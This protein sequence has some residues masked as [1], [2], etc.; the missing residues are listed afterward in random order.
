MIASLP[1]QLVINCSAPHKIANRAINMT[2]AIFLVLTIALVII[3]STTNLF[4]QGFRY[5]S[6]LI[7]G[8]NNQ[9]VTYYQWTD[10]KG[11]MVVSRI[12]PGSE[13]EYMAFQASEDLMTSENKVDQELINKGN[14]YRASMSQQDQQKTISSPASGSSTSMYPLNAISKT[15]N[16][17]RL[18]GQVADAN[19]QQD[20]SKLKKLREQHAKECG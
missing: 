3:Y 8:G 2:K 19:R 1:I 6:V 11:E 10:N 15:K 20:K 16:C 17:V 18:S 5:V 4:E 9:Q 14:N 7:S 12:K 13:I